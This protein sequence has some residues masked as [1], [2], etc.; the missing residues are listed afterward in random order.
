MGHKQANGQQ[1]IVDLGTDDNKYAPQISSTTEQYGII[2]SYAEV[3]QDAGF[4]IQS[5]VQ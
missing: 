5:V 2:I 3:A 1:L 4:G